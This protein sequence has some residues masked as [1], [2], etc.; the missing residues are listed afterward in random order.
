V[1]FISEGFG[2]KVSWN[3]VTK[4]VTVTLSET[5]VQLVLGDQKITVN[6]NEKMMDTAAKIREGRTFVP[7]RY[8][9]EAFGRNIFYEN[10]LIVISPAE[11]NRC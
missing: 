7:V 3:E 10:G 11:K 9:A 6:S 1:R 5:N 8:I 4:T 2:A